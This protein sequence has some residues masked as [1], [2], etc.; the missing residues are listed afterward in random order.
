MVF[1]QVSEIIEYQ[2]KEAG[3]LASIALSRFIKAPTKK[4]KHLRFIKIVIIVMAKLY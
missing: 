1:L 3:N 4:L 2:L